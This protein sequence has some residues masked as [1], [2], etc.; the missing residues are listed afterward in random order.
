MN[1]KEFFV[2]LYWPT[3]RLRFLIDIEDGQVTYF[4]AQYETLLADKWTAITRYDFAHGFFHR[5]FMNPDGSQE[6][7]PIDIDDRAQALAF[8][9]N[10]LQSHWETYL[11][12]YRNRINP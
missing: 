4:V 2:Y 1:R 10:D 8:A 9:K 12:K 6:K 3:D 7:T 5:D 11:T